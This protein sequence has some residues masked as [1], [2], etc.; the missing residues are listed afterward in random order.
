MLR[1]ITL[2]VA[3][4]VLAWGLWIS[5]DFKE[6]A[7]GV[8]LF[9]FGMVCLEEGFKAL[10]GGMLE[11]FLKNFTNR[12]WKSI[13]FGIASTTLMQS[14]TLVSLLTI[15][16]VSAEMITLA[17]G[18]GVILGANIGTTTGAW[19]IAGLG[20][21]VDIAAYA[22]PMLVFGVVF[23]LQRGKAARGAGYLMLGAGFLFLGIHH[24]KEGF[25]AFQGTFDLSEYAVAGFAGVLL[26]TLIGMLLT[27]IMQSSHATLLIIITALAAGQVSYENALALAIGANLGSAI[28]TAFGGLAANLGGKRL[29]VAHVIF[30]VVTAAVAIAFINQL[31]WVVDGVAAL[32]GIGEQDFLLKLALFHTIFNLLGVLLMTPF[33]GT[34]ER[35]LLKYINFAPRSAEQP[36]YLYRDALETPA[37]A[38]DAVRKE[39]SHLLENAYGV[40]AHGLSLRRDVIA[41][42]ESLADAVKYTRRTFPLDVEAAYEEKIK[43]LYS[44]I[45]EFIG[46][47]LTRDSNQSASEN[48][49]ALRQASREIV[50]VVKGMKHLHKNL[51]RYGLSPNPAVR[52]RYDAI[53][54]QLATL[55]RELRGLIQVEQGDTSQLSLDALRLVVEKSSRRIMDDLDEM[56]RH[57]RVAATVATSIMND[58]SYAYDMSQS[59]INAA[60]VLM[61]GTGS[62]LSEQLSLDDD[63]MERLVSTPD[64]DPQQAVEVVAR[65]AEPSASPLSEP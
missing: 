31:A 14:S 48:L 6:I 22:M 36:R 41:S 35:M 2:P 34:L 52:E 13:T 50:E 21:R 27:V 39:V 15:S 62:D 24:M 17:A 55:M 28:T 10:S 25:E 5:A 37:T 26:F 63:D 49:Y 3:L 38:V 43:G 12:L 11:K 32:I 8:A 65:K 40:L 23:A 29:A 51:T 57:R 30:N 56:I 20:L 42:D 60:R 33:L 44:Q 18:I 58:E 64:Q 4:L 7:T 59:L 19:L 45:V 47:A 1:K 9:L 61:V 53:R 46:E 54:L 16:F